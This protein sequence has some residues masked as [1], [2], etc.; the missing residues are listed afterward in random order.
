[1]DFAAQK[2]GRWKRLR[3]VRSCF[4]HAKSNFQNHGVLLGIHLAYSAREI[5]ESSFQIDSAMLVGQH[6][7]RA[8]FFQGLGLTTGGTPGTLDEAFDGAHE[9]LVARACLGF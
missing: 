3:N 5:S 1:M 8:K 7:L 6:E 2:S 4:A 9:G